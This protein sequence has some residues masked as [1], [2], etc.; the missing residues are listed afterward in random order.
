M[1]RLNENEYLIL[2][3]WKNVKIEDCDLG[4]QL[5]CNNLVGK[6]ILRRYNKQY[7][8]TKLGKKHTEIGR[9]K[10]TWV[11]NDWFESVELL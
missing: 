6:G 4:I 1:R 3:N 5:W 2:E 10:F 9:P 8:L 11:Q 7:I